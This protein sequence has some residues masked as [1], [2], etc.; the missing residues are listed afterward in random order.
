WE[1]SSQRILSDVFPTASH[2]PAALFGGSHL[3]LFC[4]QPFH[5]RFILLYS[6]FRFRFE[7][8]Y[9]LAPGPGG[10]KL[11]HGN[12]IVESISRS[13]ISFVHILIYELN[14]DQ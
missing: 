4:S 14:I 1:R 11:Y 12:A 13:G 9:K 5:L 8:A 6:F 2:R 3:S 7:I 10:V